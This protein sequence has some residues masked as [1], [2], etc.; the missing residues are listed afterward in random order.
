MGVE[1]EGG[2]YEVDAEVLVDAGADDFAVKDPEAGDE[3]GEDYGAEDEGEC[4]PGEAVEVGG[5]GGVDEA[6]YL[7]G[8]YEC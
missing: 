1:V 6:A 5:G 4:S 3:G 8:C 2:F 7:P